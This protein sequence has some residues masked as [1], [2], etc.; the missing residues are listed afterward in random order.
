M[1]MSLLYNGG[2]STLP[3]YLAFLSLVFGQSVMAEGF[4][5]SEAEKSVRR[6]LGFNDPVDVCVDAHA[7]IMDFDSLW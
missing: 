4:A 1:G 7:L 5:Y 6:D 3:A 2:G